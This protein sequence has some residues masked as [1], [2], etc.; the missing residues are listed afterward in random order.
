M[1]TRR[2]AIQ[3]ATALAGV[4]VPAASA[5]FTGSTVGRA[6]RDLAKQAFHEPDTRLPGA[7]GSM[8]YDQYRGIRFR[9]DRALWRGQGLPFQIG[10]FARGFLYRPGVDIFE[11]AERRAI[12]S[13]AGT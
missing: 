2:Q 4:A 7:A 5:P 9:Q 13:A 1:M 11:A 12:R 8:T 3:G 10:F 6:A